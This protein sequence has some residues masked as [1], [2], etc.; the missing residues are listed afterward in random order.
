MCSVITALPT[1]LTRCIISSW[2]KTHTHA[3]WACKDSHAK[4]AAHEQQK[5]CV[6]CLCLYLS[7]LLCWSFYIYTVCLCLFSTYVS[8]PLCFCVCLS[9]ACLSPPFAHLP[10]SFSICLSII[11][12][13][14]LF[15]SCVSLTFSLP[16]SCFFSPSVWFSGPLRILMMIECVCFCVC[17]CFS[18]FPPPFFFHP[19]IFSVILQ[20]NSESSLMWRMDG[21]F[22]LKSLLWIDMLRFSSV[23]KS[24]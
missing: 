14:F 4:C 17:V 23:C 3:R 7:L 2:N 21:R 6:I 13:V 18:V 16:V 10:S 9:Y 15:L 11:F 22:V 20:Y 12:H 1:R 24:C 5:F 8:Q 19:V